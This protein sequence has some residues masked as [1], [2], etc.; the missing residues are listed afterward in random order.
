MIV[1]DQDMLKDQNGME[2]AFLHYFDVVS[3]EC[4]GTLNPMLDAHFLSCNWEEKTVTLWAEPKPWMANPGGILHGGIT[5]AYLDLTMG[6]LCRYCSGGFMPVS[7]HMDVNYLRAIPLSGRICIQAKLT[8]AG[9]S[10]CF[11]ESAIWAEGRPERLLATASGT[12]SVGT[13]KSIA[14]KAASR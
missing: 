12:Y 11:A 1:M 10:I 8:R 7:I 3:R 9:S 4:S 14:E 6:V 5:A 13:G 2:R